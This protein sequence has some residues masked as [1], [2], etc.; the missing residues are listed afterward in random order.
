[1]LLL[2]EKVFF[3]NMLSIV[4]FAIIAA[5][6]YSALNVLAPDPAFVIPFPVLLGIF[7]GVAALL[8]ILGGW[9]VDVP[10]IL[11]ALYRSIQAG[12]FETYGW[13]LVVMAVVIF[14][15]VENVPNYLLRPFV[16][17][18]KVDVGLLMLA[19]IMGPAIFGFPGLFLGAMLLVIVT[20]YFRIVVPGIR[21]DEKTGSDRDH[22]R[23]PRVMPKIRR[24]R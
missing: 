7:S 8:P 20:H 14:V 18:G 4:F 17:H 19:Y 21:D 10:I 5:T 2:V 13:Y 9:M 22:H 24:R 23:P 12:V 11:Y 15:L 1:M 3:G 6:V 16:S